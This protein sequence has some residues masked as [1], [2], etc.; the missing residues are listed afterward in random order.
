MSKKILIVQTSPE[1]TG[2]TFLV[3]ALYGLFEDT[4]DK[5]IV[6]EVE[7]NFENIFIIKSHTANIDELIAK[8][9]SEYDVYFVCS[10]RILKNLYIEKK[11][12]SYKNVVVF[13]YIELN[14]TET[15]TLDE[16]VNNICDKVRN[17]LSNNNIIL[18][19]QT[20]IERIMNMNK[21][22]EEIKDKPFDY[23]DPFFEIHGS[24]RNRSFNNSSDNSS[25]NS[26]KPNLNLKKTINLKI[27]AKQQKYK[28]FK[29]F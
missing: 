18:N 23:F 5:K 4:K 21:R 19:P 14:E 16:I 6:F 9:Q 12:V 20:A 26:L 7:P 17:L 28:M 15:N 22:Y 1:H 29:F 2:S 10:Q 25:N 24:H 13:Q 27:T 3:N 8:Y 11:Y